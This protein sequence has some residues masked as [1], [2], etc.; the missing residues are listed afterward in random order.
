MPLPRLSVC[1]LLFLALSCQKKDIVGPAGPRGSTGANGADSLLKGNLQGTVVLYD[2]TG[3]R[4]PDNSGVSVS[5]ENTSPLIQGTTAVDGTFTLQSANEG[6]YNVSFQKQGFGTMRYFRITNTGSQPPTKIGTVSV[7]QQMSSY[8][9]TKSL[10]I[11]TGTLS[12]Q[13]YLGFT[14]ILA[15]PHR[16]L[17]PSLLIYISDSTG[18]G[19]AH[20]RSVF[21][22]LWSQLNDSTLQYSSYPFQ[23]SLFSDRLKNANYL[24]FT[25]AV[26]NPQYVGYVDEQ[27]NFVTPSAAKSAPEVMVNNVQHKY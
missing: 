13:P 8:N 23:L 14:A 25:V 10:K 24:Y 18:V 16:L 21:R 4:L 15:H 7:T 5:L 17:S 2:T 6:I 19:N 27:G 20:N 11:D 12:N 3:A 9:D 26:D 22:R 1:G